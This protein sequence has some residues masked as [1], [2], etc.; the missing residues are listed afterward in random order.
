MADYYMPN[1]MLQQLGKVQ[2]NLVEPLKWDMREKVGVLEVEDYRHYVVAAYE[3]LVKNTPDAREESESE[4]DDVEDSES[5]EDGEKQ[6][7]RKENEAKEDDERRTK[8]RED[9]YQCPTMPKEPSLELRP[10][11]K[12]KGVLR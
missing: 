3:L 11:V 8:I 6:N 10:R 5:K 9:Q 1:H 2:W 12:G 7:G 4:E